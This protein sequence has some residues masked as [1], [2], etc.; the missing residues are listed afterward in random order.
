[1][2]SRNGNGMKPPPVRLEPAG[3]Y[4]GEDGAWLGRNPNDENWWLGLERWHLGLWCEDKILKIGDA[5]ILV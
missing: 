4:I 1:M 3:G 5:E 2:W